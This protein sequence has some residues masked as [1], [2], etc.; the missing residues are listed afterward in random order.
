MNSI[1]FALI[2]IPRSRESDVLNAQN[3]EVPLMPA[4]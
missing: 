4:G 3:R 2:A 1:D